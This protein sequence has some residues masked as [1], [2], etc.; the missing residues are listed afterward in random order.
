MKNSYILGLIEGEGNFFSGRNSH[1]FQMCMHSRDKSLLEFLYKKFGGYLYDY[2]NR[3][4]CILMIEK[5][6]DKEKL[7]DFI[8]K[9]GGFY[10]Y[11]NQQYIKWKN[12]YL[13]KYCSKCEK[14][15][16]IIEK[17][18]ERYIPKKDVIFCI[19]CYNKIKNS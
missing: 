7:I 1:K 13:S 4:V 11:K 17:S 18:K 5:E 10:G 16:R 3:P 19:K 2:K 9:N 14:C 6:N 15:K 8:D 12:D